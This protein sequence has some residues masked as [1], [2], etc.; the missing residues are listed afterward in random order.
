MNNTI[1]TTNIVSSEEVINIIE[2]SVKTLIASPSMSHTLPSI[3]LR[4]APGVGKS[5]IVKEIADKLGIGFVDV[6]LAQM[7]R[8]DV[9]GL[10]V[11][12]DNVTNWNV[13]AFWPRDPKS[14]GIVFFDEITSAPADVQ[15]AAYS[16]ILDRRIPNSNYKLP[17]GWYIIAAGNRKEDKA[18][19]KS[20]SSALA[21]RFM[22]F[23]VEANV[24]DWSSWAVKHDM[25]PSVTGYIRYRP[26]NL[27]KMEGQDL[28]HGWPSPRSWER[29]S[30]VI[31][32]FNGNEDVLRKVVYGLI[33]PAVGTE[34]MEFHRI[35][36]R[37]DDV[38]KMMTDPDA[39]VKIPEKA[40]QK[41]A[42]CS[43]I[44]Y[45]IWNGKNEDEEKIRID[46]MY[47]IVMKMSADFATLLVKTCLCGNSK[48]D[49]LDAAVKLSE[50]PGYVKFAEKFGTS[51]AKKGNLAA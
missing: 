2:T 48:V 6:R 23:D 17:D 39:E 21:N 36:A 41:Y 4:G 11:V 22:H 10:P 3:L 15:V 24:E 12:E 42:L 50:H 19:A 7:E 33:G 44:S 8:V 29:V 16:I 28:E 27:F 26:A 37:F 13:P 51:F 30:S 31:P 43:A 1:K 40:D 25:H 46:G 35:N 45:L 49:A 34:F 20:M 14:K 32:L 47:R 5:T 38:L 9:C 18:V